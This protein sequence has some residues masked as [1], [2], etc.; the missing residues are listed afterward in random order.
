MKGIFK[1][2]GVGLVNVNK[3]K[4]YGITVQ[5][6]IIVLSSYGL[7]E[8][9]ATETTVVIKLARLLWSA[10]WCFCLLFSVAL[11]F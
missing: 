4:I 9:P 11:C 6:N 8:W 7:C 3:L 5:L 1:K 2:T 10:I